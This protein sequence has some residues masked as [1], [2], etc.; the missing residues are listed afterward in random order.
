MQKHNF[1]RVALVAAALVAAVAL[2]ARAA[3]VVTEVAPYASGNSPYGA[4]WFELTNTGGSAV[5]ITGWRMDDNSNLFANSRVLSGIT[6]IGAGQSVVFLESNNLPGITASFVNAW[7]NGIA[8]VG[9]QIG[10]Y[11]GAGVGLSTNGDAVNIF[12]GSGVLQANV[13]FGAS[14]TGFSFDNGGTL[15][16]NAAISQLSVAG[17][18]G[19][20]IASNYSDVGSPGAVPE[21]ETYALMLA[22]LVGVGIA[23]QR[24]RKA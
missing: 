6:S 17:V 14:T 4:D 8:P 20:F 13:T 24:R 16:N 11:T 18:N 22:G 12:D 3:I 15:L 10:N 1:K 2:P 23:A 9:L 19:A 21:P 5:D 7:F